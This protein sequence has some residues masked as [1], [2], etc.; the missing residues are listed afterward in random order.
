[1][2]LLK[3]PG[4]SLDNLFLQFSCKG[5]ALKLINYSDLLNLLYS[6]DLIVVH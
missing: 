6:F 3:Y 5:K 1:M 4:S 2:N